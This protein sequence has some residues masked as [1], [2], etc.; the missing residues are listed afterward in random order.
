ML[1]TLV[2]IKP[3]E[4]L[5]L[6]TLLSLKTN[7]TDSL[8]ILSHANQKILQTRKDNIVPSLSEVGVQAVA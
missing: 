8:A 1:N 2:S 6:A 3:G 4:P 5:T 7:T